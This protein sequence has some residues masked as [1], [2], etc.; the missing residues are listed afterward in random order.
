MHHVVGRGHGFEV[1]VSETVDLQLESQS[2]LQVAVN[3][4]LEELK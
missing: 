1:E 2:R 3:T 4:V